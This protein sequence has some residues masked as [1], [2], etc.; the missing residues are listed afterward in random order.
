MADAG[1]HHEKKVNLDRLQGEIT[2]LISSDEKRLKRG[3]IIKGIIAVII[4]GY[5]GVL[6]AYSKDIDPEA[7]MYSVRGTLESSIPDVKKRMVSHLSAQAPMVI[8]Q[9][10]R[11][12]LDNMPGFEQSAESAAKMAL[13]NLGDPLERDLTLW[14]TQYIKDSKAFIDD[15]YLGRSS[16]EKITELR[17]VVFGEAR[18]AIEGASY[19]IGE[20]LK[21]HQFTKDLHRLVYAKDLNKKEILQRDILAIWYVLVQKKMDELYRGM[22][23]DSG[24]FLLD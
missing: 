21:D 5:L 1:N 11:Q 23:T 3:V 4:A 16:Y 10:G 19:T 15:A 18:V 14:L 20:N 13:A 9:A 6:A 12:L 2:D 22:G 17:R 7:I 8:D 24:G